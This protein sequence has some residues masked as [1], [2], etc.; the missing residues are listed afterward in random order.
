MEMHLERTTEVNKFKI[1]EQNYYINVNLNDS[2]NTHHAH[3]GHKKWQC[4]LRIK[5]D[6]K[7]LHK[8]TQSTVYDSNIHENENP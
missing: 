8:K 6:S 2:R 4:I 5:Q 7:E 3:I 1:Y